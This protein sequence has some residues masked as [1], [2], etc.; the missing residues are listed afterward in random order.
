MLTFWT[1]SLQHLYLRRIRKRG[2]Q[3]H[4]RGLW[5]S[6]TMASGGPS[7]SESEAPKLFVSPGLPGERG[8]P[9]LPGPKGDEGK[10]GAM[11]P[12]GMRGFKGNNASLAHPCSPPA[13]VHQCEHWSV[14]WVQVLVLPLTS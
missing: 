13:P 8:T 2:Q 3:E 1:L 14:D 10:L 9:G 5:L 6:Q 4:G 7:S 11:G 12:M